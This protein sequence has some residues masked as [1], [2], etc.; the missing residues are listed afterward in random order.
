MLLS[1]WGTPRTTF[2]MMGISSEK[3]ALSD[4]LDPHG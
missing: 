3:L 2:R 4:L 1:I